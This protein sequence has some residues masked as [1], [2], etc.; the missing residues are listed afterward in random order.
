MLFTILKTW[1]NKYLLAI[2][3]PIIGCKSPYSQVEFIEMKKH[4]KEELKELKV[5]L[6]GMKFEMKKL[7]YAISSF[8]ASTFYFHIFVDFF[9]YM[10]CENL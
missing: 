4:L 7:E 8:F 9:L 1:K 6:S 5:N 10:G 2:I 3:G